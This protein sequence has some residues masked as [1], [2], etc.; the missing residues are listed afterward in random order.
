MTP[1]LQGDD[2]EENEVV[3][4]KNKLP[5]ISI[6]NVESFSSK[7]EFIEKVKNQNPSIKEKIDQGSEFTIVYSKQPKADE[8][9]DGKKKF[10]QIVV[11]VSN[12][13]MQIIK[14][15]DHK[16]YMDL[17]AHRVVDRFYV[18]RCNRCQKFGHYQDNCTED[19]VCGYCC[20][21]HPSHECNKV[22]DGHFKNYKCINCKRDDKKCTGHSA[23]WYKC[24]SFVDMQKKVKKSIPFYQKN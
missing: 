24:P 15:S 11:R 13:I 20:G 2:F 9:T 7:E 16:I 17:V 23:H 12:D 3:T 8:Q 14:S 18:K 6:L 21:K 22:T 10:W 1:L 19:N 4:I 5:T